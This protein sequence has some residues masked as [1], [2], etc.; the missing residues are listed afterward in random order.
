MSW[1][2]DPGLAVLIKQVKDA[3]PGM[4]V[5]T[6]GDANHASTVSDHNPDPDGSVDAADFMIRDGFTADDAE[7]LFQQLRASRDGRI[8]YVIY[9]RRIFSRTVSPWSVRAYSGTDPHTNHVHVSVEDINKSTTRW[10]VGYRTVSFD[11]VSGALPVLK[12]GDSDPI[13][14][15]GWS[16]V[17]RAQRLLHV[18]AD[19]DY[20]PMT[21]AAV[22]AILPD[23][24]GK[25]IAGPLWRRLVGMREDSL[26]A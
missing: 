17:A 25:T 26:A 6:I 8:K 15:S 12:Y 5:Y 1:Y 24:D 23:T 18:D 11:L 13:D 4:T 20:G 7:R 9:N 19:G 21:Q 2:V 3:N 10:K 16:H 14:A 22:K